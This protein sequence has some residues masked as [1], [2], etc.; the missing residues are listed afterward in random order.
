MKDLLRG[1]NPKAAH[2][3]NTSDLSPDDDQRMVLRKLRPLVNNMQFAYHPGIG[4]DD[5]VA[6]I[7]H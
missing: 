4:E 2:R 1:S 7:L 3:T 6:Y 5:V